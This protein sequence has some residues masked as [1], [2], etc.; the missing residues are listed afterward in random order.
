MFFQNIEN[1][2][3]LIDIPKS[4]APNVNTH[5]TEDMFIIICYGL[6]IAFNSEIKFIAYKHYIICSYGLTPKP[7]SEEKEH[8]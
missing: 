2:R 3:R 6:M 7:R 4:V 8:I 1:A 5:S